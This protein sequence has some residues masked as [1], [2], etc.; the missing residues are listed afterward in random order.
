MKKITLFPKKKTQYLCLTRQKKKNPDPKK[1]SEVNTDQGVR[2]LEEITNSCTPTPDLCQH[3]V[4]RTR[5]RSPRSEKP[6][7]LFGMAQSEMRDEVVSEQFFG[8]LS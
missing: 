1:V 7:Q 5:T 8:F 6:E 4:S 2:V 3:I